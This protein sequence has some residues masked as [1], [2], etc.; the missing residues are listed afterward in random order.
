MRCYADRDYTV[1]RRV[2][3]RGREHEIRALECCYCD[4]VVPRWST[5]KPRS[6]KSGLGRYNRMRGRMVAHLHEHHRNTMEEAEQQWQQ[7][8]AELRDQR[9]QELALDKSTPLVV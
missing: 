5:P 7:V 4:F 3:S 2:N 1:R 8:V 9:L 6:S